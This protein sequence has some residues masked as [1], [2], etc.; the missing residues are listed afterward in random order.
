[1]RKANKNTFVNLCLWHALVRFD[2]V[3]KNIESGILARTIVENKE[4][5]DFLEWE[6]NFRRSLSIGTFERKLSKDIRFLKSEILRLG[7]VGITPI[8][9]V[10]VNSFDLAIFTMNFSSK[11]L[12]NLSR[13]K[14]ALVVEFPSVEDNVRS[15]TMKF[16]ADFISLLAQYKFS[17]EIM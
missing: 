15:L 11:T 14:R 7:E 17:L 5:G 13:K 6:Y 3:P 1:M 10:D 16:S 4:R 8:L 2:N 12:V 9:H